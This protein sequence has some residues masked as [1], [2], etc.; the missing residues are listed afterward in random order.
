MDRRVTMADQEARAEA[1]ACERFNRLA[2]GSKAV[3]ISHRFSTVCMAG[4]IVGLAA[5]KVAQS[6]T[7]ED[8]AAAGGR[9]A[10]RVEPLLSVTVRYTGR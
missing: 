7:H 3:L 4:H 10:E 2:A 9:H 1:G 8:P 6:G 5:G